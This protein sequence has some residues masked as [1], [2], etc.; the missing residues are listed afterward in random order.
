MRIIAGKH[1]GRNIE[2]GKGE[3]V[4]PTSSFTRQALFNILSHGEY[5]GLLEDARVADIF[6]GSGALGLE[7]LSRGAS[8]VTFV[9]A[10]PQAL[11]AALGNAKRYGEEDKVRSLLAK[12]DALPMMREPFHVVFADPPYNQQLLPPCL[13][14]LREA[15][16]VDASSIISVEHDAPE[17]FTL[18]EGYTE[19]TQR[20]YG[21]AMVRLLRLA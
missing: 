17:V 21:R 12:G 16:W 15:G 10:D 11:K 19:I 18:P 2:L 8:H 7:A 20:Q 1:K 4:R 6:C 5:S 3:Q 9:D 13:K 14:R